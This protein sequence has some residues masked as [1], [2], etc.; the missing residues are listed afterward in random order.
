MQIYDNLVCLKGNLGKDPVIVPL[1]GG[2]KLTEFNLAVN[3]KWLKGNTECKRTDWVQVKAWAYLA[4]VAAR[5]HKGDLVQIFGELQTGDYTKDDV[6]HY[7]TTVIV[8]ELYKLDTSIY[9]TAD[10]QLAENDPNQPQDDS[11][12]NSD[13]VPF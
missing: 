7:T 6:K 3:K 8:H 1:D 11:F 9:K 12:P 4:D 10:G 2:K 5:L 13:D